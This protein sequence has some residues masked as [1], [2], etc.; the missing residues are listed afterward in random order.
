MLHMFVSEIQT[1]NP[2]S[3]SSSM[4]HSSNTQNALS[5]TNAAG[6]LLKLLLGSTLSAVHCFM[7]CS[8]VHCLLYSVCKVH[9]CTVVQ[10]VDN[11][12]Q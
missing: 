6:T 2:I 3:V 9:C 1:V 7:Y 10:Y 12:V 5:C 8:A 11:A 4:E